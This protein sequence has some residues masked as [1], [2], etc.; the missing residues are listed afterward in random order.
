MKEEWL[1][2]LAATLPASSIMGPEKGQ[3]KAKA[4]VCGGAGIDTKFIHGPAEWCISSL[5]MGFP[6]PDIRNTIGLFLDLVLESTTY[7]LYAHWLRA[8]TVIRQL[9]F[10]E[11][12]H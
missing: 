3:P 7:K 2:D 11:S 12:R 6:V 5:S 9:L 1:I 10:G 8:F 4:L